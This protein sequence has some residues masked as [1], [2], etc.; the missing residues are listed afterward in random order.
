MP[1]PIII[2]KG[3]PLVCLAPMAGVTDAP[4]RKQVMRY[5]TSMVCS[6][7]IASRMMVDE[8]RRNKQTRHITHDNHSIPCAMQ[9]AGCDPHI[10]AEAAKI[11][12]DD[13]APLIDINFG[14]PVKKVVG[15]MAGSALMRDL[16]KAREIIQSVVTSVKIPVSI[17][18]RLGWDEESRNADELAHIAEDCGVQMITVHGR[19]RAQLYNGQA[20]WAAVRVVKDSVSIPVLVNGDILSKDDAIAALKQSGADGVMIGRGAQGRPWR[21][22]QIKHFLHHGEHLPDPPLQEIGKNLIEQYNDMCDTYGDYM[23]NQI[24]RKHI[25]W[26]LGYFD[27]GDDIRRRINQMSDRTLVQD[28]LQ[29]FFLL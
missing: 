10:M 4:F 28:S 3:K 12:E 5:G 6:E 8:L 19:T 21:V 11:Q 14:C 25:G 18:M 13:G 15:G 16:V 1:L 2:E 24:A 26:T 22:A 27:D 7:M 23:G 9:L 29:R 20:D 17:K